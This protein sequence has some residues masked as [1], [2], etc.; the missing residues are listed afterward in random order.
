M[1]AAI[2]QELHD[3]VEIIFHPSDNLLEFQ[4]GLCLRNWIDSE[5]QL[6]VDRSPN[7]VVILHRSLAHLNVRQLTFG[8][9]TAEFIGSDLLTDRAVG[10][11]R[12]DRVAVLLN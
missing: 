2:E 12:H 3:A 6:W 11:P 7:R 1:Q 5:C 4:F 8:K 9:N 10:L